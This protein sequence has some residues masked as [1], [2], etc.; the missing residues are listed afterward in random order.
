MLGG[1][2]DHHRPAPGGLV[3]EDLGVA[4]LVG[5]DVQDRV[6][7]VVEV[8]G[9]ALVRGVGQGLGLIAADVGPRPHRDHGRVVRAAQA[10]GVLGVDDRRA[11]EH[12][13]LGGVRDRHVQLLPVDEVLGDRVAPGH[14][15]PVRALG[16]VLVEHVVLAGVV[17]EPVGVVHPVLLRGVVALRAPLLAGLVGVRGRWGGRGDG[18]QSGLAAG[19]GCGHGDQRRSGCE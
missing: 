12:P 13:V 3:P 19:C 2:G 17:D 8:P 15:A 4:E 10:G 7:V 5:A 1:V 14:V 16:V 11:G 18:G 9:A 6:T